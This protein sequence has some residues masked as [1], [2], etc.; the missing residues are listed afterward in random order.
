MY[1][2]FFLEI[3]TIHKKMNNNKTKLIYS[4]NIPT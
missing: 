2:Y 3:L 4:W 1:A